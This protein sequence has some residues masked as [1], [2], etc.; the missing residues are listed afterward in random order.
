MKTNLQ[1]FAELYADE[2]GINELI[3]ENFNNQDSKEYILNGTIYYLFDK[4][5][6]QE[7]L[8]ED[9]NE[10]LSDLIEKIEYDYFKLSQVIYRN[11]DERN[12]YKNYK[13]DYD[14]LK[15]YLFECGDDE[16]YIYTEN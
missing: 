1:R 6:I 7:K 14:D 12:N 11:I 15:N 4:E 16:I 10:E 8:D 13:D 9:F 2:E 3:L 5:D